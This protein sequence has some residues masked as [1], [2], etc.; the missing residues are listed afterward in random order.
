MKKAKNLAIVGIAFSAISR[1]MA[2]V[3]GALLCVVK[4]VC[5][6]GS[7]VTFALDAGSV[8]LRSSVPEACLK[9]TLMRTPI[10]CQRL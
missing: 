3:S 5:A 7:N 8:T 2:T 9:T 10:R 4:F 1:C 6:V